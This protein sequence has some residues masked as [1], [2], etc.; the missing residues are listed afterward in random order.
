MATLD[1]HVP[2]M[3]R[4]KHPRDESTF[5]FIH[6]Q[7]ILDSFNL[8]VEYIFEVIEEKHAYEF[9]EVRSR[10]LSMLN[11]VR[12]DIGMDTSVIQYNGNAD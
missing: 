5:G 11:S 4:N 9:T 10:A 7:D 1:I 2:K 12:K 6:N 8:L 3:S